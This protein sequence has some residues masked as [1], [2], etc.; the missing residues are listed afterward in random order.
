MQNLLIFST[1]AEENVQYG[2]TIRSRSYCNNE[3]QSNRRSRDKSRRERSEI[4]TENNRLHSTGWIRWPKLRGNVTEQ[5]GVKILT[6]SH[7]LE[8]KVCPYHV[9]LRIVSNFARHRN[10]HVKTIKVTVQLCMSQK[11]C[12]QVLRDFIG[13]NCKNSGDE[14]S[15]R[16]HA[17]KPKVR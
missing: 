4:S 13:Q 14:T 2:Y 7:S 3:Q 12:A 9:I 10:S 5:F 15:R 1:I 11:A 8:L 17:E 6:L 16:I